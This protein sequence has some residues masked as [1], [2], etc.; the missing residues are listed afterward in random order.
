MSTLRPPA[1]GLAA[2]DLDRHLINRAGIPF[3]ANALAELPV[4]RLSGAAPM[5]LAAGAP[6]PATVSGG[7]R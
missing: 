5:L 6:V 4:T 7:A 2:C 1:N 3:D